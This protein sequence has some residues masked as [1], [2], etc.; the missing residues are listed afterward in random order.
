MTLETEDFDVQFET[1][2]KY[3]MHYFEALEAFS[4]EGLLM[5]DGKGIFTKVQDGAKV[6]MSVSKITGSSLTSLTKNSDGMSQY[7][8]DF[9]RIGEFL[10]GTSKTSPVILSYPVQRDSK[11]YVH[12]DIVDED[13]QFYCP[14]LAPD[15]ISKPPDIDPVEC[16][17]QISISG[18]EFKKAIDHCLKVR[19]D[20]NIG[21]VVSTEGNEFILRSRDQVQGAVEKK[22]QASG[23]SSDVDL[24]NKETTISLDYL[25]DIKKI[26]GRA[27]EVTIHIE[28]NFPVRI[29]VPLDDVGDA[30][31]IYVI[32][33]RLVED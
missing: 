29:D 13:V 6:A 24:G 3:V 16:E 1:D 15:A 28:D 21:V 14:L 8:I 4:D 33:P 23:P 17:T 19:T 27:D 26:I 2:V 30:R 10:K 25:S 11:H 22:F 18:T 9:E 31:I 7:G 5:C 12:I 32:A 20:S